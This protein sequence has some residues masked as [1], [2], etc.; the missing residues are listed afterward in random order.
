MEVFHATLE[1]NGKIQLPQKVLD[2][3]KFDAG[4][5]LLNT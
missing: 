5:E 3:L 2:E 4:H 1:P